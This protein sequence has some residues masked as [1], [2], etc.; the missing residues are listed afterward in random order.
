MVRKG[1]HR[2]TALF[3]NQLGDLHLRPAVT[4]DIVKVLSVFVLHEDTL[5]HWLAIVDLD[6]IAH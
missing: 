1:L 5:V 3:Y 4:N 2:L 6:Y